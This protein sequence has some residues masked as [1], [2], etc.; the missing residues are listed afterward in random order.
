MEATVAHEEGAGREGA[1]SQLCGEAHRGGDVCAQ[2]AVREKACR[3]KCTVSAL[4][5]E[6][7]VITRESVQGE[8]CRKSALVWRRD[9]SGRNGVRAGNAGR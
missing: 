2:V 1:E 8:V 6:E 9:R 7:K 3:R 4:G 5:V